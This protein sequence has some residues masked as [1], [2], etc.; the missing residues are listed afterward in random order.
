MGDPRIARHSGQQ[1]AGLDLCTL[2]NLGGMLDQVM[3][4]AWHAT[5]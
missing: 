4:F 3:V 5:S 2:P 1:L